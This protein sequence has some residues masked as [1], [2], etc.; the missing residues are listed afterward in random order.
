MWN[1]RSILAVVPARGGSKGISAKN[2]RQVGGVSL[3]GRAAQIVTELD[4]LDAGILSTDDDEI[5]R[6]GEHYGLESPV[7]RPEKLASDSAGS[8]EMW[9]HAWR[10]AEDWRGT[11]FDISI[12]LEPTSPLR[13]AADIEATVVALIESGATS[14]VTVSRNP[15]HFTPEKTLRI[16][17]R[18]R[19][20]SYL[21]TD[22]PTRQSIAPY[23][24]RNG[25]CYAVTRD[26][27]LTRGQIM[28]PDTVPV[29]IDRP[30]VN[31]DEE[32]ELEIAEMLLARRAVI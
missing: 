28:G 25:I 15:A 29:V 3:V 10:V 6:E 11:I 17:G 20:V 9:Q 1:D 8:L 23:Y 26:A 12:L 13:E 30:V 18:G 16:D 24:H 5:A 4:W 21:D 2:L 14:A 7:R 31:I 19:L 27:L 22:T 32:I